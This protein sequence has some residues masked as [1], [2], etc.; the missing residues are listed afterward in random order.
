M[1]LTVLTS[2]LGDSLDYILPKRQRD[3]D[4]LKRVYTSRAHW[5]NVLKLNAD[6][7]DRTIPS[8]TSLR[9]ARRWMG[10]GLSLGLLL[11]MNVPIIMARAAVQLFDEFIHFNERA[12][13]DTDTATSTA[14]DAVIADQLIHSYKRPIQAILNVAALNESVDNVRPNPTRLSNKSVV[15]ELFM[16]AT[17]QLSS[18]VDYV[19]TVVSLC[20]T[21][22]LLYTK[23]M[24]HGLTDASQ[25]SAMTSYVSRMDKK[26][27]NAVILP[28]SAELDFVALNNMNR[29]WR[30]VLNGTILQANDETQSS[31][32]YYTLDSDLDDGM[33]A[34]TDG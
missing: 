18:N 3:F 16:P 4:Y 10:L 8:E 14:T 5:L 2:A 29:Q 6:D 27:R 11:D 12:P 24:S 7:F 21:L 19:A 20:D 25:L 33:E 31:I 30:T 13:N 22:T 17:L 23:L 34:E 9:R 1:A 26:V 15:Y 28:L 32:K